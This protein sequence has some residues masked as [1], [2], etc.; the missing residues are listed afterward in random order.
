[1]KI[2]CGWR[3]SLFGATFLLALGA[4]F[5]CARRAGWHRLAR[6]RVSPR[7]G[8]KLYATTMRGA[9]R[10]LF[11]LLG[12]VE[13]RGTENVPRTG[14]VLIVPN[15]TS[16]ADVAAFL[17]ALPRWTHC[18]AK[19]ELFTIPVL[20]SAIRALNA[21]PIRRSGPA[22]RAALKRVL[23]LLAAGESVAIFP[24]GRL[25]EDGYL[26]EFQ[27]GVAMLALRSGAPVIP[28][29]VNGTRAVLPYGA[30]FP[31]PAFRRVRVRFGKPVD[32]SGLPKEHHERQQEATRRIRE[33][34]VTLLRE[35]GP[36]TLRE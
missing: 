14:P 8:N 36:E 12:P 3:S 20:G 35:I 25:S 31:R 28:A 2:G 15:H 17:V 34:V 13:A 10:A 9:L 22:D 1:M 26:Q 33:G 29:A 4:G 7:G 27:P 6:E 5:S 16:D 21:F 30:V 23:D 18:V 11:A 19:E 24:E 32:L